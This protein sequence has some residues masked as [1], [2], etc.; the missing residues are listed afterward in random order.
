MRTCARHCLRR[1]R[2]RKFS[3]RHWI[4]YHPSSPC[5]TGKPPRVSSCEPSEQHIPAH[6]AST[7]P[8]GNRASGRDWVLLMAAEGGQHHL[9]LGGYEGDVGHTRRLTRRDG[10]RHRVVLLAFDMHGEGIVADRHS[11]KEIVAIGV[12]DVGELG[13]DNDLTT[14]SAA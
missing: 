12:G 3:V 8:E 10:D 13:G 9:E 2:I 6:L 14:L 1:W 5:T 4:H 7:L 11:F